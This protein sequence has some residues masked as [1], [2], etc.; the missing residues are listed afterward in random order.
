MAQP[1]KARK[2]AKDTLAFHSKRAGNEEEDWETRI[3]D[4]LADL[5]HLAKSKGLPFDDIVQ[6]AYR[7]FSAELMEHP[8]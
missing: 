7:N 8:E 1:A 2:F 4:L 3:S 5:M 6:H